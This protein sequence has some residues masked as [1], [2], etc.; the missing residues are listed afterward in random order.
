MASEQA[1]VHAIDKIQCLAV[2]KRKGRADWHFR[3]F[4]VSEEAVFVQYLLLRPSAWPIEFG[5]DPRAV[6]EFDQVHSVLKRIEWIAH[7][8]ARH[9]ACLDSLQYSLGRQ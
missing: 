9:T 3:G 8:P 2:W 4:E 6:F 7:R 1:I 5:Y